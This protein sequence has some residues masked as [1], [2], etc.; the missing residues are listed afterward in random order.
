MFVLNNMTR[1]DWL[2][3]YR[4]P[5]LPSRCIV[6]LHPTIDIALV[7]RCRGNVIWLRIAHTTHSGRHYRWPK[8]MSICF[9]LS[10]VEFRVSIV[11]LGPQSSYCM[12]M[13]S[14][15]SNEHHL[16]LLHLQIHLPIDVWHTLISH[17]RTALTITILSS[18]KSLDKTE[19]ASFLH[20]S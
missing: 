18:H 13:F 1:L 14:S 10:V 17:Q 19:R 12:N 16:H 11:M 3:L 2:F 5:Q 7:W 20:M 15:L 8:M 9:I 4:H 6:S